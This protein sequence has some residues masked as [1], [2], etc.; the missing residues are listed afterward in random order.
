MKL[1]LF[2]LA[3]P[4]AAQCP[5]GYTLTNGVCVAS[6][7]GGT[8]TTIV[9]EILNGQRYVSGAPNTCTTTSGGALTNQADCAF[10]RAVDAHTAG[11]GIDLNFPDGFVPKCANW[12][13][14][15]DGGFVNLIG[16]SI[17]GTTIVQNCNTPTVPMMASA[18]GFPTITMR[19]LTFYANAQASS[20]F[21]LL[22]GSTAGTIENV[23]CDYVA[24]TAVSGSDHFLQIG[25]A[26]NFAQDLV[27][28]NLAIGGA[29]YSLPTSLASLTATGSTSVNG[30]TINSGGGGYA[31]TYA[32]GIVNDP[33]GY[34][35]ANEPTFTVT[36][37]GGVVTGT[38]ITRA[39]TCSGGLPD[40]NVLNQY[41]VTY[42]AKLYASDSKIDYLF[43]SAGITGAI[44]FGGMNSFY[45]AHPELIQF[46]LVNN[47]SASHFSGTEC[48]TIAS[49]CMQFQGTGGAAVE[50]TKAYTAHSNGNA[51]AAVYQF[52]AGATDVNFGPQSNLCS[53]GTPTDYQE[54]TSATGI[55]VPGGPGWPSGTSITGNDHACG[56]FSAGQQVD[57]L[58][59]PYLGSLNGITFGQMLFPW[60]AFNS[61]VWYSSNLGSEN[62]SSNTGGNGFAMWVPFFVGQTTT[63]NGLGAFVVTAGTAGCLLRF[64]IYNTTASGLPGT[65]K[66]DAG[67][68]ACTTSAVAA[69]VTISQT[70]TP[71]LYWLAVAQQGAPATPA[72][73]DGNY[74]NT[75]GV[76]QTS[77]TQGG[78]G[79][80]SQSGI[81]A[82]L[83]TYTSGQSTNWFA[84]NL[85]VKAQ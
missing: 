57:Y 8:G 60:Q 35:T 14:P 11:Q 70:L 3:L 71:G 30:I 43:P 80:Y 82:A 49:V 37:T 15:T 59:N 12:V 75:P 54:F 65:V 42:A 7:S 21:D 58:I 41:P 83:P 47:A 26:V 52:A 74:N 20:C 53:G 40:L 46:G 51:G 16:G 34:C 28:R 55:L 19:N 62:S 77:I 2:L 29:P 63:F 32:T 50:G 79:S 36:L 38:T 5:Q 81:T 45:H 68:A 44:V 23:T 6:G 84:P 13:Q 73:I 78:R 66:L 67:T 69:T 72:L 31:P 24:T 64:G 27:I 61:G 10:F 48:D 22:G 56:F 85:Y 76:Y 33:H 1:L 39:G 18:S 4:A 25:N 17:S 9:S